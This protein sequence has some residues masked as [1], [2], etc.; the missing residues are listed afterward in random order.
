MKSVPYLQAKISPLHCACGY[1]IFVLR[2]GIRQAEMLAFPFAVARE[3]AKPAKRVST[4]L[5]THI[6]GIFRHFANF[7]KVVLKTVK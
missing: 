5:S 7:S 1:G 6:C 4:G 3:P 2:E